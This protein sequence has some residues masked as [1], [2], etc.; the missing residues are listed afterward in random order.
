[1]RAK[2]ASVKGFTVLFT[3]GPLW[4]NWI[5]LVMVLNMTGSLASWQPVCSCLSRLLSDSSK[6]R[7]MGISVEKSPKGSL[8]PAPNADYVLCCVSLWTWGSSET[9]P[10]SI[11]K[12]EKKYQLDALCIFFLD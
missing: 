8:G 1:M 2:W 3:G 7:D 10:S 5:T 12:G 4:K 11:S 6:S 9:S